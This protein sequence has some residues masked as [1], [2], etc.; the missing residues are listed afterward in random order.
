MAHWLRTSRTAILLLAGLTAFLGIGSSAAIAKNQAAASS[1]T[2]S[3]DYLS[4]AVAGADHDPQCGIEILSARA[5]R[6]TRAIPS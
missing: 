4:A 3:G 5:W 1:E 6:S 2:L